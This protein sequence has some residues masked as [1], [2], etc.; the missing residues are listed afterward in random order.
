MARGQNKAD[1]G[2]QRGDQA[3]PRHA[4]HA[5]Q[6]ERASQGVIWDERFAAMEWPATPDQ[7][8]VELAG[9]IAPG[10]ALDLGCGPGRNA[11]WLARQR[12]RVTGV[13]ASP[14]GLAQAEVRARQAGVS[15]ELVNAD[16]LSYVPPAGG[17]DLV[18]VANLH[19]SSEERQRFFERTVAA[20]APGGH[21]Y[22]VGHHLDSL[23]RAGP[24]VPERLYT[25]PLLVGLLAPLDVE[26]RRHERPAEDGGG[27]LVEA[28][29]WATAPTGEG[30]AR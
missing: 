15:L 16:V 22:V 25:E 13:D 9:R 21:L 19:F 17:F 29:A 7:T 20:V 14:V 8:L 27:P 10:R 1:S 26:V 4:G 24:P 23:R 28:V 5:R 18:V 2:S 3:G 11:I 6:G 30:V 12:W